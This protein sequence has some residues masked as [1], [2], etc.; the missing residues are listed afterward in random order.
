M[1]LIITG[2][3]L[4]VLGLTLCVTR[5]NTILILAGIELILNAANLTLVGF[6]KDSDAPVNALFIM[7]IAAAETAVLLAIILQVYRRFRTTDLDQISENQ[8]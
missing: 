4:F 6:G 1:I 5:S 7:A 8:A 2:G 3:I